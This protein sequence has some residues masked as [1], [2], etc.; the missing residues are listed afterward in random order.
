MVGVR[1]GGFGDVEGFGRKEHLAEEGT[2]RVRRNG[3]GNGFPN[4]GNP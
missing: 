1:R 2:G 4:D 3:D